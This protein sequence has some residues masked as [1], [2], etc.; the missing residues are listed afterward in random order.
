[1]SENKP[2]FVYVSYIATSADKLWRALTDGKITQEYWG[3][4]V[5][6]SE[7]KVGG[8]VRFY[9]RS[10][11]QDS[12]RGTVLE[13][14]PPSL[15]AFTWEHVSPGMPRTPAT[16][17]TFSIKQV[18]PNNVRLSV[19]HEA[20]EPGTEVHEMVR[21]GWSAILSSLKSQLETGKPLEATQRWEAEGR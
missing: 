12:M 6:E 10:D 7:W 8:P 19:V 1:M 16:K 13:C 4:R 14:D 17:V 15:L 20:H 11:G 21:E 2:S 5:V 18:S 3:G 9:K